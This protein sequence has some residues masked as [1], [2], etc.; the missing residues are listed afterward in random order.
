[1][2]QRAARTSWMALLGL[3]WV[4]C[5]SHGQTKGGLSPVEG[6]SFQ[7]VEQALKPK[8]LALVVGID[9]FEDERWP[10]LQ[11]AGS[12]AEEL[13]WLLDQ[14]NHG[15]FDRVRVLRGEADTRRAS[16]LGALSELERENLAAEDTVLIYFSTHGT[17]ARGVSGELTRYLVAADTRQDRIQETGLMTRALLERFD[18]LTSRRKVLILAS[19]HSGSGKSA[20]PHEL[21][22]ELRGIKAPFFPRPLEETSRASLILTACAWGET[23]REDPA[24]AHDVYT[25]FLLEALRGQD[26]DG[27]GAITATEAHAYAMAKTYYFSRGTQH[28]EV[29][30]TISGTDPVVLVGE[31]VRPPDPVLFSFLPRFDGTRLLLDGQEK[32]VLPA[33]LSLLPGKYRVE[34]RDPTGRGVLYEDEITLAKGDSVALETL[35]DQPE[36]SLRLTVRGGVQWILDPAIRETLIPPLPLV[37]VILGRPFLFAWLEGQ[38]H[39]DVGG[40]SQ[41]VA[42]GGLTIGQT[43]LEIAYGANAMIRAFRWRGL[44]LAVGP[45]LSA[46]HLVRL[47]VRPAIDTQTTLTLIPA[48]LV[49]ARAALGA[50]LYLEVNAKLGYLPLPTGDILQPEPLLQLGLGLGWNR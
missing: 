2:T 30:S 42:V 21:S 16:I 6:L 33:R 45:S 46:M 37:E 17:L 5:A 27:D 18:R 3:A 44:S 41:S 28:P 39:L 23:A 35:V 34:L 50:R 22:A 47:G 7:K 8:R 9:H 32:G 49:S 40:S 25:F 14:A 43:L 36:P 12:D 26:S 48:L 10:A 15:S 31:R 19:C 13:G 29:E 4:A 20:L 24:L 38:L 1:M 11:Y